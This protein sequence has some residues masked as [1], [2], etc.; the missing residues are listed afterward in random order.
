[1]N[2]QFGDHVVTLL[3]RDGILSPSSMILDVET[4]PPIGWA[5]FHGDVLETDRFNVLVTNFCDLGIHSRCT[6]QPS[7]LARAIAPYIRPKANS[8]SKALLMHQGIPCQLEGVERVVSERELDVL[9]GSVTWRELVTR[10]LGLGFGLTPSGDD[11]IVGVISVL[12]LSGRDTDDLREPIEHYDNPFSRT[13]LLGALDGYYD[14]PLCNLARSSID[15]S[16]TCKEIV[17][18]LKLG[19]TSGLDTLSGMYYALAA[20]RR[21]RPGRRPAPHAS[22]PPTPCVTRVEEV[23][24]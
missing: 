3:N 10:L 11:F 19:H 8:I 1:M 6:L 24:P 21:H 5:E 16:L 22:P 23:I 12:N 7:A 13:M 17:G 20:D 14:E 15:G 18:L 4:L 9:T 2:L